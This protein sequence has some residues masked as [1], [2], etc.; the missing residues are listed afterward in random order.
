MQQ[1]DSGARGA[2]DDDLTFAWFQV[3]QQVGDAGS[4]WIT[5]AM[6]ATETDVAL[7]A[8]VKIGMDELFCGA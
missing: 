1:V 7:L 4:P 3:G 5:D 8:D 2:A 6:R